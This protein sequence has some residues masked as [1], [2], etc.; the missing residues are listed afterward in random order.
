M[1]AGHGTDNLVHRCECSEEG[2]LGDCLLVYNCRNW[3]GC[4]RT[5]CFTTPVRPARFQVQLCWGFM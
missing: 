3:P 2:A 4:E 1:K 5:D